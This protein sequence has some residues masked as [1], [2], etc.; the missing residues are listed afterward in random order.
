MARS[1]LGAGLDGI[2]VVAKP[3]G[4][5][6]HDVVALVRRLAATKRGR[7]RRDAG[8]VRVGRPADLPGPCHAGRRIPPGRPKGLPG[9]RLLR[10]VVHDRRPRGRADAER[11][12][13][14]VARRRAGGAGRV[15]RADLPAAAGLQRD[16]GRRPAGLRDGPGRRARRSPVARG[17]DPRADP[18]LL[19]RRRRRSPGRGHRADLLRRDVRPGA[20]PRSRPSRSEMPPTWAP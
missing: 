7:P 10:R 9:D 6:S 16:Q 8:S 4:P 1:S 18:G 14:P 19:G 11:G 20:R 13:G 17:H 12:A 2:L 15:Q 3:A 5:T